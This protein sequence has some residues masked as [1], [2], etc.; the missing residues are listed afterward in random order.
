[1]ETET[2]YMFGW[3]FSKTN[4]LKRTEYTKK[5]YALYVLAQE[6]HTYHDVFQ[7]VDPNLS[8]FISMKSTT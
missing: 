3:I 1:M 5:T 4:K 2:E 7:C 6:W 8:Q